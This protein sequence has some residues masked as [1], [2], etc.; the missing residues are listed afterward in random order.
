MKLGGLIPNF[1]IH[2]SVSDLYIPK[3]DWEYINRSQK[4]ECGNLGTRPR[5]FI[6][7]N[8]CF[9]F[10]VPRSLHTMWISSW[11]SGKVGG[12]ECYCVCA[13][14]EHGPLCTVCSLIVT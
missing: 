13:I 2:V 4:H 9:D 10:S 7:G 6:S 5:S 3:E 1:H 8:I 14:V 11:A 12:V